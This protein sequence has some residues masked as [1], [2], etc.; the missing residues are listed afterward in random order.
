MDSIFTYSD[1]REYLHDAIAE[2]RGKNSR[3]SLRSAAVRIGISSGTLTRILNGSRHIG[4]DLLPKL[5]TY[6]GL[7]RREAEYFSLLA[8]FPL[9][10]DEDRKRRC[11][12]DIMKMRAGRHTLIP[13]E[14]HQFFE[15][16]YNV[17]LYELLRI[18]KSTSD[19]GVLGARLQPPVTAA[20][21][22]K[23]LSKLRE[24]G[25]LREV[26]DKGT[27]STAP[28]LTTGDKWESV[29]IHAFQVTMANLAAKALD[30]IP[31]TERDFSTLTMA[32]S[33][34]A[35]TKVRS[36]LRNARAEITE[37]E[38]ECTNPQRV[39]QINIQC[40]PLSTPAD[41]KKEE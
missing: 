21:V 2:K 31:K 6:L 17:V 13:A 4:P 15:H 26:D 24:M 19:A 3:Y 10:K 30:T 34:E 27:F 7:K 11:Y 28:F 9:I 35:F 41:G 1:Y 32:L 18:E 37:I 16:W 23:A 14:N 22:K 38:R 36:V 8:S 5:I 25:Y 12:R 29:A 33:E 20:K 39:Y 40:F